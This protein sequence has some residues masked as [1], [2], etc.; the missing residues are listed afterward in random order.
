VNKKL[1]VP[2]SGYYSW[3]ANRNFEKKKVEKKEE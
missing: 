2:K 3:I 1:Q